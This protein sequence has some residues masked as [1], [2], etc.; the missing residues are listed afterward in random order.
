ME[1]FLV[2]SGVLF[3]ASLFLFLSWRCV[4]WS[5]WFIESPPD[6]PDFVRCTCP[7]GRVNP[8]CPVCVRSA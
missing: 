6:I 2:L 4:K 7:E 1:R 3:W 5:E 8:R